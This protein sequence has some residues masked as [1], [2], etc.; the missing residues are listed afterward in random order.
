[1]MY[2][3][4]YIP[5]KPL[6]SDPSQAC[7]TLAVH[8]LKFREKNHV[9]CNRHYLYSLEWPQQH[10]NQNTV[11]HNKTTVKKTYNQYLYLHLSP[12]ISTLGYCRTNLKPRISCCNLLNL[13]FVILHLFCFFL[14]AAGSK[15]D[16]LPIRINITAGRSNFAL[17]FRSCWPQTIL[18]KFK[19]IQTYQA[20][21]GHLKTSSRS[22]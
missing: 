1:M 3:P 20:T 22:L 19:P 18:G 17:A 5:S 13:S 2:I 11:K 9:A 16:G 4:P 14:G 7:S 6:R 8:D 15:E 21:E 12:T 10:I